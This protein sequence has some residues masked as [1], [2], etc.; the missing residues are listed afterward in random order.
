MAEGAKAHQAAQPRRLH[1]DRQRHPQRDRP[2]AAGGAGRADDRAGRRRDRH[3]AGRLTRAR[4]GAGQ[5]A[6]PEHRR[7]Q[8]R[9]QARRRDADSRPAS[10]CRSSDRTIAPARARSGSPWPRSCRAADKVAILEGIPTAFN[11]QQRRLGFEDAMREAGMTVVAVQSAH[12]EQDEANTDRRRAAARAPGSEGDPGQQRQH[13][14]R[15]RRRRAPGRRGSARCS[16]PASTTSPPSSSCSKEGRIAATAD[17]HGDKL[18]VYGIEYALGILQGRDRAAGSPDA[19]RRDRGAEM[20]P[21]AA[22]R[23]RQ[24]LRD[25]G[26]GRRR[27]GSRRRRGARADGRQRR[28]Q[29]HAVED[30]ERPGAADSGTMSWP[31]SPIARGRV[32]RRSAPACRSCCR[33]RT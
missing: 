11:A 13:G 31:A 25:A 3:R 2:V 5:G 29:V 7:R 23:P 22:A 21:A 12:W 4:A 19:G 16:S 9:Q 17:Q 15:R 6:A 8:H 27:P 1:A 32:A 18:A 30:R 28:R 24:A 26:A 10:T 33:S 14:A 20:S